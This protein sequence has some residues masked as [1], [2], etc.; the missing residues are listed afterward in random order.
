MTQQ[1]YKKCNAKG[2]CK[3]LLERCESF[4]HKRKGLLI[5]N[6]INLDT[7][8]LTGSLLTYSTGRKDRGLVVNYCPFC[9]FSF[10]DLHKKGKRVGQ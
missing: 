4:D 1:D 8:K 6:L 9:G 5:S 2:Y 10:Y 3:W 7:H